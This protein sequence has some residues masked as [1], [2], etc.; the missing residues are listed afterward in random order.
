VGTV[1]GFIAGLGAYYL[2]DYA[3]GDEIEEGVREAMGEK[4]CSGKTPPAPAPAAS[5]PKR[6]STILA[7]FAADT[8]VLLADRSTRPIGG[9]AVGDLLLSWNE[10]AQ[11]L[12]QREVTAVHV[13]PPA[14]MLEL[15]LA[16]GTTIRVTPTHKLRTNTGW[17]AAID[18]R[19]GD[20]L[21]CA[22]SGEL[23]GACALAAVTLG[24]PGGDVYD[25]SVAG[26]H[27]YFAGGVLAHNKLP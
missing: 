18:L 10:R 8:P 25:L 5:T 11:R 21:Q 22:G 27:T 17:S 2:F 4:G 24:P 7:C 14:A 13:H 9:V 12:E 1:G 3:V 16:D 20:T 19:P 6:E 26:T 15:A 23:P